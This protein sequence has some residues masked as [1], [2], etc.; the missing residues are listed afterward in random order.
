MWATLKLPPSARALR[1]APRSEPCQIAGFGPCGGAGGGSV[2]SQGPGDGSDRECVTV[3]ID[4]E[5]VSRY[6]PTSAAP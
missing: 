4:R 3:P 6:V 2:V 5:C 1:S